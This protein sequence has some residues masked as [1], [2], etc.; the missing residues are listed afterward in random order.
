[1]SAPE[2]PTQI[3]TRMLRDPSRVAVKIMCVEDNELDFALIHDHL[4]EA[5]FT[6]PTVV[7]RARTAAEAER[8]LAAD[9]EHAAYD[10]VLLD[11]SLPDSQG[12][13]T[14]E[15]VR[16]AAPYV[17]IAILS[18]S[19]DEDL[20]LDLVE[21]GGQDYL[22]KDLLTPDLVRRCVTYAV[23]RQSYRV[24]LEKLAGRLRRTTEELK[25]TQMQLIRAEK[26]ESLGRL[27]SSVAHEVKN[28]LSVI[29][30]GLD[31]LDARLR[32]GEDEID[33]TLN[34][35]KDAV[36]R[37]DSVIHDMLDV[38]RTDDS[39]LESWDANDIIRRVGRMLK[40]EID[41]R[42]ILL[43]MELPAAPLR[44]QCDPTA[45]E[46]VLINIAMN[47]LQ[48]M[49]KGGALTLRARRGQAGD[50]PRDAGLRQMEIMRAGADVVI[51]EVQ[52]E[53]PGIP[54]DII[55]RIFEPFFTTKPTGEGTGLGLSVCKRIVEFHRG[56]LLVANLKEPPGLM[57]SVILLAEPFIDP[58]SET[59]EEPQTQ[60]VA[61]QTEAQHHEKETHSHH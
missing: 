24:E 6:A 50:F 60:A 15:R 39:R 20:A 7:R 4:K 12:R 29:Q 10:I 19:D 1:M 59:R 3:F 26:L 32:G 9:A 8:L 35:M 23:K 58:Q 22:P 33:R 21:V 41:R 49:D 52:D 2:S 56:Q 14:F 17:A 13:E 51:I 54:E 44:I 28:P 55:G 11:L 5:G 31:F 48:A 61:S 30:M 57:L 16:A 38:S 36:E 25:T 42:K 47:A 53:G 37:A 45:I 27:A 18:G 43:R 46:Q 34:L 40:H